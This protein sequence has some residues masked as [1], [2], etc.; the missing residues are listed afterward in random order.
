MDKDELN[1]DP[2]IQS[3]TVDGSTESAFWACQGPLVSKTVT[4]C[5]VLSCRL[6]PSNVAI[7]WASRRIRI[8]IITT[9]NGS[10]S[11]P[12]NLTGFKKFKFSK[13]NTC[14]VP[15]KKMVKLSIFPKDFGSGFNLRS[16]YLHIFVNKFSIN[17]WYIIYW[18]LAVIKREF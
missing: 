12:F 10:N 13:S 11:D 8:L 17:S 6:S 18:R 5:P 16:S 7:L 14:N 9:C 3:K 15:R 2:I 1:P 4:R